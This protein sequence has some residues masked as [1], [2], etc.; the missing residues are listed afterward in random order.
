MERYT[1]ALCQMDSQSDREANLQTAERLL[2]RAAGEGAALIAFPELFNRIDA[3]EAPPEEVPSGVSIRFMAELARRHGVWVL[4]GSLH[5]A[6]EGRRYNTSVLLNPTGEVAARYSKLHMFD[7]TLPDGSVALE[8]ALVQPGEGITVADTPLGRLGM[9]ICYDLRFPEL[10]RLMALQGAEVL[11][12]PAEFNRYTGQRHWEVLLRARA[13]ENACYVL[14]PGQIGIKQT[15]DGPYPC[16]GNSMIISPEGEIL[17]RLGEE[18]GIALAEIDLRRVAES[19][20]RIPV[21][22]NRRTDIYDLSQTE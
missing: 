1:V 11:L 4:C 16:Y 22:Q 6:R 3:G 15:A 2:K 20:Q 12:V 14:A 21:L 7:V 13:I 17:A 9:S 18:E 8:S 10:Y 19:R 5:E